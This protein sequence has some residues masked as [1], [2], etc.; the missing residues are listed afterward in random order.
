MTAPLLDP[1]SLPHFSEITPEAILP[2]L[3][4]AIAE[5]EAVVATLTA[6]RPS[7]FA[8][9]WLP[10]ERAENALDALWSAVSHLHGVA[11][12]PELRAAHAEGQKRLIENSMKVEQNR[13]LY[14]VFV[15]LS[16]SPEFADLPVAD[17]VAVE[18]AIRD[19]TLSGVALDDETRARF[20]DVSIELSGLS[21][22][23]GSAVLDA[24]EAWDEVI[25]D[26]AMLA[27]I[28][29]ADKAMFRAAAQAKGVEGWRITLQQPSVGAILTFAHDRDL[30]AR[31]YRANATRASD[32]GPNAGAFD[33]SGRI[34][35]ILELRHEAAALLGFTDPVARSLATKMAPNAGEVLAFLRDL[36]RRAKPAAERDLAELTAF[37]AETLGIDDLQPWDVAFASNRLRQE[38]Y[39]IDEQAVRAYFPVD[40]VMEGWQALLTRLFG[41]RL[42]ERH[43]VALAHPDA[44]FFDVIDEGGTVVSGL[45]LDLH[46]RPGKRGGAWMA[47]ARPR[48]DDGNAVRVPVAYLVCN[49]APKPA[50]GADGAAPALLSHDDVTTLLHETGHG[51]HHL[52]T[53]VNRPS[54]AGTSGFEWDAVELP[55]QLMEDFAWD[56]DV[57]TGMSGH[58]ET[59]E[60]LPAD[61][62]DRLV[63]ARRFQAG[64]FIVRQV[65]FALFD[66]LLHLGTM[67]SDPIEVIEAVRDEVAVIRPPAWNRFP[68][69]FGHIFSG[70]Y[71]AGYY[72]YLWAE[73]LAA[74][75]FMAFAE[76]GLVDRGTGDRFRDEVLSRGATRPAADSFRAFRGRDADPTAMLRRHGLAEIEA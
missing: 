61:L 36:A 47:Q 12:T 9:A 57:L 59:G 13:E 23:F 17:R 70:G 40:R 7:G 34:A 49:F 67:G 31:V 30:R 71:A 76:A 60:R 26:E 54:I 19:F 16:V 35:R 52:F 58:Y 64:L 18:H 8:E 50:D 45:Y 66:L 3:D 69:A 43:D 10:F 28:S 38:R 2:A 74:D 21:T 62:F 37:A 14:D 1:L 5:H 46:A 75:G 42:V 65:E 25:T 4:I 56:R 39:A 48:L 6:T 27:G 73:L 53:R 20:R 32:Q 51:L 63:K 55:S 22:A 29:D 44:R 41:I 24:T 68:H 11:D 72:S 33:N 15:A